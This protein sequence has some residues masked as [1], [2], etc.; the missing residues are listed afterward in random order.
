MVDNNLIEKIQT[1]LEMLE[2]IYSEDQVVHEQ[3]I[4]SSKHSNAVECV[5]KL[6][7]NTGFNMA[8]VAVVILAKFTFKSTVTSNRNHRL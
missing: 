7:P 3:A 1:E 2:S 8:K 6:M 5:F 4:E